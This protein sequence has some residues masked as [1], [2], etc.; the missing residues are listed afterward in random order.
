MADGERPAGEPPAPTAD[1]DEPDES[2]RDR[3]SLRRD[4]TL[5]EWALG[6]FHAALLL[7]VALLVLHLNDGLAGSLDAGGTLVGSALYLALLTSTVVT[8]MNLAEPARFLERR[9]LRG[10]LLTLL[11][12][13]L[14][15]GANGL[16]FLVA[17]L[18][19]GFVGFLLTEPSNLLLLVF[20]AAFGSVVAI[21]VGLVLGA[22]FVLVDVVLVRAALGLVPGEPETDPLHRRGP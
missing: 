2:L 15:G 1:H 22:A 21:V 14:G 18:V 13:V 9:G 4:L 8:S 20:V 17:L 3:L 12:G 7:V 16:F 19:V 6:S 5:F 11:W 10:T